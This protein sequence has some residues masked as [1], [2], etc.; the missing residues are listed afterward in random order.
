MESSV[1]VGEHACYEVAIV[2][3]CFIQGVFVSIAANSCRSADIMAGSSSSSISL[4]RAA[5]IVVAIDVFQCRHDVIGI[6]R[7][8]TF[9]QRSRCQCR[10]PIPTESSNETPLLRKNPLP[11]MHWSQRPLFCSIS[12]PTFRI[13]WSFHRRDAVRRSRMLK[14]RILRR[15]KRT[16]SC[17]R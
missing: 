17:L 15:R 4:R 14:N 10:I 2:I 6:I 11:S 7:T 3:V 9:L 1:L 5:T 12:R 13:P 8:P 16:Y